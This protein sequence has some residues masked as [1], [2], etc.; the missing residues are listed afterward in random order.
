MLLDSGSHPSDADKFMAQTSVA[1]GK[2]KMTAAQIT[3]IQ[4]SSFVK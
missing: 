1:T 3:T 2:E 4:G